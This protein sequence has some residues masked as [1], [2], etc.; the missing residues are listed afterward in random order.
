MHPTYED[1]LRRVA[2]Y[3]FDHPDGD[4]SLDALADVAAMSRFHWHRVFHAMTGETCAQAVRRIRAHRAA[5]WLVQTDWPIETVAAKA[6][7]DNVQSFARLFR[8]Q[9]G[10]TPRAFRQK[11]AEGPPS[12]IMRKGDKT[13]AQFETRSRPETRLAALPHQGAYAQIGS[14]FQQ[15]AAVFT[16][17]GL[18]AHAGGMIGV[19]YDSPVDTP[20]EDLRS[21][22]GVIVDESFEMLPV[23]TEVRLAARPHA[24]LT[25]QG[26]YSGLAA[27]W[28]DLYCNRL[29]ELGVVPAD[30]PPFEV[31]LNDP[32]NTAPA[33]LLTE[34]CVPLHHEARVG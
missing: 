30:A 8:S 12:F 4:L 22:A 14:A 32:T 7:Y 16:A 21:H 13:M 34:I 26:P 19:Y 11:G 29:P 25:Y 27:A 6:G 3:I 9:Y 20:E 31:Y 1:R 2:Q 28:D 33:D 17:R 5:C 15:V 18:W 23:L 24:V 10:M